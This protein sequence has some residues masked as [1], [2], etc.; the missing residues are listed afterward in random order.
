[1]YRLRNVTKQVGWKCKC[2]ILYVQTEY[3]L[4]HKT[5]KKQMAALMK[6]DEIYHPATGMAKFY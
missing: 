6:R 1:M 3:L 2:D 4:H 5:L